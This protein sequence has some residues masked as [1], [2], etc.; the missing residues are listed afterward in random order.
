MLYAI[1]LLPTLTSN[2]I[3]SPIRIPNLKPKDTTILPIKTLLLFQT[4]V[5]YKKPLYQEFD[6]KMSSWFLFRIYFPLVLEFCICIFFL[7]VGFW[8]WF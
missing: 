6:L 3:I 2:L 5:P 8:D 4:H 7:G 1:S